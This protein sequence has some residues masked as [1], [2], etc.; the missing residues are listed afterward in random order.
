MKMKKLILSFVY[1]WMFQF[2]SA[3]ILIPEGSSWKY[4][5]DGSDQGTA[6]QDLSYNDN[7]WSTGDAQLGYGDGDET[8]VISYG[9][10]SSNKHI[11]YYFRKTFNVTD[12][13]AN[14]G[15]KISL[16]RDDGAVVYIN[17]TEV[18][19]SNMPS[20]NI[21]YNTPAA[22]TVSGSAESVFNEY[23]V[24]S[25]VL[26]S[27]Q[28]IIAVEVHQKSSS[29]SDLSFDLKLEFDVLDY[30]K[31]A[32]YV[33]Y[34]GNNDE[35][36]VIWQLNST[37][38]CEFSYGTDT[39]YSSNAYT[40][41]EYGN[42]H[43]HKIVLTGLTPG[44]KYYY[45]V[46]A[47]NTSVKKGSFNAGPPDTTQ[48]ITFFAYGDTRSKPDLHDKVAERIMLDITQN[49]LDQTFIINSGDLVSDG[50][51]EGSWDAEFFNKQYTHI[52]N[53]LANLP[54]LAALGNHEGQ[55]LLFEKYFPFPMFMNNRYYYSF[56]YGPVHII[57]IDQEVNYS[58]GSTQ[59]D[60]I[61][62]D[63]SSSN[64]TWKVAVF[65]EPGWSAGGHS[66]STNVQNTLQP[67]FEQYNVKLVIN[68]HNHYYSHADVNGVHH[69]TTGGGGAPLYTPNSSSP[70]I[71][72]VDQSNHYCKIKI[73]ENTLHFYAIR[74]NG[75]QIEDFTL[76]NQV[77]G[78]NDDFKINNW[79]AYSK[80]G[81]IF[82]KTTAKQSAVIEIYD[83]YGRKIARLDNVKKTTVFNVNKNGVYLVRFIINNKFSVK[84]IIVN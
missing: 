78:I 5:D 72:T 55:G 31:K 79:F 45:K 18:V 74:S 81:Q 20:G 66:N 12:P 42:D 7:A 9:S 21:N 60:W 29:S 70:N 38:T 57:V 28:N 30:Y 54:Y 77:T 16:L 65:H 36:L 63:L 4:L 33:L 46:N 1:L 24:S 76:T 44:Q 69:I 11:C 23:S 37:Q 82:V 40:T 39:T 32:P 53:M 59:Y 8:T 22:S 47:A 50:D 80:N 73:S 10:S 2:I 62:N 13:N 84:K 27:G 25:S 6:W 83:I 35:M 64:K 3:Q 51:T 56:D 19:R 75:T 68:G 41:N 67:L 43:Q 52:I 48:N 71:V 15:I 61:V 58:Q 14:S 34:T 26:D 17:G 49:N